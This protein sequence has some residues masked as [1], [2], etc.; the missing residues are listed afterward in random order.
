MGLGK[1]MADFIDARLGIRDILEQNLTKYLL[2]RNIN[3]WYTLGAVL[4]TLFT[5]QIATGILLLIYYN[6]NTDEAFRSVQRIMNEVPFGWLIR[7]IHAVGSN[8]IVLALLLHMLSVLFMGSYKR[9][10]E[11]TWVAGFLLL[12]L[13]LGMC[14]TGYLLPWSQLSFWATT[15][16]TNSSQELPMIGDAAV[17]F[18]RGGA[19]VGQPTL[20][21]FFALHVMGFPLLFGM[22]VLFHLFCV[23]RVGI[24]RPPFGHDWQAPPPST[25]FRHEE[26][27]GGI[28][29]FPHYVAK[30][31]AIIAF[32]LALLLGVVFFAPGLFFPPAA[33]EPADP[34][35]TPPGIKPEWYFLWAYQTLKLLP[36]EFLGL[37]VQGVA[38]TLLLLLPFLD[39]SP[40]RRPSRRPLFVSAYVLGVALFVALSVWGHYS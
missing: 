38:V 10:R 1:K 28:P 5:V 9:P 3:A 33:F 25:T 4:L 40:E 15:V 27:P 32:F 6:P 2:P 8:I 16:A 37:A 26:H 7:T 17:R 19:M 34:F 29:F 31:A 36:S 12:L 22:L 39:R 21:R 30:D 14:L 35:V 24:S 11:L 18:L 13:S 20:G 23:R